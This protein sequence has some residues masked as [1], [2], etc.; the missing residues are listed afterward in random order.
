MGNITGVMD[1]GGLAVV[2]NFFDG[3]EE[4]DEMKI[5][6]YGGRWVSDEAWQRR[7]TFS[8]FLLRFRFIV[9]VGLGYCFLRN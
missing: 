4:S 1:G 2:I 8:S 3:T 6:V 5:K 7:F 9:H